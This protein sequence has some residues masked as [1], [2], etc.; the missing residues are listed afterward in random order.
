VR[1][2]KYDTSGMQTFPQAFGVRTSKFIAIGALLLFFVG[3]LL[4]GYSLVTTWLLILNV[5]LV[6]L[7]FLN[8]YPSRKDA[9]YTWIDASILLMSLAFLDWING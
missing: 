1:D 5:L 8:V 4:F 7:L 9:Y 6:I 3:A 2:L